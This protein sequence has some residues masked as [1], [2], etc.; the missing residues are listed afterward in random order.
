MKLRNNSIKSIFF[1]ILIISCISIVLLRQYIFDGYYLFNDHM[2]SDIIRANVPAYTHMYD[3]ISQGGFFWSWQ[4]G[5]GT[6]MFSHA[7]V[8][9]DPFVYI[10]FIFGRNHIMRMMVYM[11]IAKIIASGCTFYLYISNMKVNNKAAIISS[12]LYSFC[13]YSI[14]MGSNF[15]L[16]TILV[17]M[18]L[19]LLGADL[20]I[21]SGKKLTLFL[22]LF[23]TAMLS[24]YYF[25]NAAICLILYVL[26]KMIFEKKVTIK[27]I[28]G[29]FLIGLLS[30][31]CAAFVLLPQIEL[32]MDSPRTG[33]STDVQMGK[34]MFIPDLK[35]LFT[36]LIRSFSNDA[37]GN[38]YT[39]NYWGV[40]YGGVDYFS[41]CT[42]VCSFFMYFLFVYFY[43]EDRKKI[44]RKVIPLIGMCIIFSASIFSYIFNA[45][46]TINARWTFFASFLQC[47]LCALAIE[48]MQKNK[49]II[50]WDLYIASFI[51]SVGIMFFGI[52]LIARLYKQ[53][54]Y[55]VILSEM[56]NNLGPSI[57][58]LLTI[59]IALPI[60]FCMVN[61][62]FK[63]SYEYLYVIV[64]VCIYLLDVCHN[65]YFWYESKYSV[66]EYSEENNMLYTDNSNRIIST[67]LPDKN[68]FYRINKNF[69]SVVEKHGIPSENDAM[70]Q[71][72]YG[73]KNYNS[74]GNSSYIHFLQ[75]AGCYCT[76]PSNIP[77]YIDRGI[78]PTDLVGQELN[79]INGVENRY[80]LMCYLGVKY[81]LC[82]N[83]NDDIPDYFKCIMIDNGIYVFENQ[84]S[85][86]L[87]F[88]NEL[89]ISENEYKKMC[90]E[91]K[92]IALLSANILN[93]DCQ[94]DELPS[95]EKALNDV[96]Q[97]Q[98]QFKL[99]S[100]ENDKIEGQINI[101]PNGEYMSTTIP[102][103]KNWNIFIDGNKA[104]TIKINT[105][106][107][108]CKIT[109][110]EH[111]IV[112]KYSP[113]SF[114]TG[115]II[116]CISLFI[117]FVW[118]IIE[119][120]RK[121][122]KNNIL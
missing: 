28:A 77:S 117:V 121:N 31:G 85:M 29:F 97:K 42:F 71:G 69:D 119:L 17:Y 114:W 27:K 13:G 89:K 8:Y 67:I 108:G 107:V 30:I 95:I 46:S 64:F 111:T 78:K 80:N 116:S 96:K 120:I 18:P 61:K 38:T 75:N 43:G 74:L 56:C 49:K 79:Y 99:T 10:T 110:G 98:S 7:D 44:I 115:V 50:I 101:P 63:N 41:Q 57:V 66:T 90:N 109:E 82:K 60:I 54:E 100:F 1:L 19:I 9:F 86:P 94:N 33:A 122:K 6:S 26:Y 23:L 76:V 102:F 73:L 24:Y 106:F 83:V 2:L 87:V 68:E 45:F 47:V 39:S 118:I 59:Y 40:S 62:I 113:T 81:Y 52:L 36:A 35:T 5:I 91:E 51:L 55:N 22:G 15:A 88:C 48:K 11:Y 25:Y 72:Y 53:F 16:G 21:E 112:I 32:V 92:D 3:A 84:Y 58:W 103:D 93:E 12:V 37:L 70:I 65:Y 34:K 20:Y 14:I 4:M 105:G 104:E